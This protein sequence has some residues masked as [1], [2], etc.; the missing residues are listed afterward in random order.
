[1]KSAYKVLFQFSKTKGKYYNQVSYRRFDSI[2][3]DL[4]LFWFTY[5]I[6]GTSDLSIDLDH[7]Y[8]HAFEDLHCYVVDIK[9]SVV[10]PSLLDNTEK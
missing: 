5:P 1:L 10:I 7:V 8:A 6:F 9:K 4:R 2:Q 3:K